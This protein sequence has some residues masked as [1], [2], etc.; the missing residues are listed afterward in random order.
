[1][2]RRQDLDTRAKER[3][4]SNL[5]WADIEH[6]A[7][8]LEKD[9]LPQFDIGTIITEEGWL[10]P[11]GI[12]A[13]TKKLYE[14]LTPN[15]LFQIRGLHSELGRGLVPDRDPELDWA[16]ERRKA[17]QQAFCPVPCAT[18]S[19][20]FILLNNDNTSK[21]IV[22]RTC[23]AIMQNSTLSEIIVSDLCQCD[24]LAGIELCRNSCNFLRQNS[25][26]LHKYT[27]PKRLPSR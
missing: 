18:R 10:H 22:I 12:T 6:D 3:E 21:R 26:F 14:N 11:D 5:D 20:G 15:F 2:H 7:V 25:F 4:V 1:M 19:S 8:E 24:A 23:S 16:P 9:S 17:R 13:L 27:E